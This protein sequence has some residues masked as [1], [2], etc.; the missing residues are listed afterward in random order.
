[1]SE[2]MVAGSNF[3]LVASGFFGVMSNFHGGVSDSCGVMS[4]FHGG[5]SDSCW[6]GSN[7][8]GVVSDFCGV[9]SNFHGVVSDFCGVGSN[10]HV[11]R[12]RLLW[13]GEQLSCES[14]GFKPGLTEIY[15]FI[16][17]SIQ[18]RRKAT[19]Q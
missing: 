8:H 10:F 19:T 1:V 7:F 4:N 16:K 17:L 14:S 12:E 15:F 6:V 2:L 18:L 5:V 9:M 13:G 11:S 3:V